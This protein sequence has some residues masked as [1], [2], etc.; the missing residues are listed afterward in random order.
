M[1]DKSLLESDP[2]VAQIMVSIRLRLQHHLTP[3][4]S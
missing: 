1:L 3:H 4:S 2:E